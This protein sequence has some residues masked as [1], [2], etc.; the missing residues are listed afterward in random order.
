[1]E[2][3]RMNKTIQGKDKKKTEVERIHTLFGRDLH[4]MYVFYATGAI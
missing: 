4:T 1:M 2:T 3:Q